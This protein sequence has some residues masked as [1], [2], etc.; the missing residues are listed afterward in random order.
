[1]T[2]GAACLALLA[3]AFGF[4][5]ASALDECWTGSTT[6]GSN[7]GLNRMRLCIDD[8][9]AVD[10]RVYFPNTPIQ[11]PPTI[12][13]ST[14]RRVEARGSTFRIVTE[15]GRCENGTAMGRYDLRCTVGV[16][17]ALSCTFPVPSGTLVNV[18]LVKV[19]P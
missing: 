11:E 2:K 13:V 17:D 18:A 15:V 6:N 19:Q 12:C 4:Q 1:M 10:L 14:G 8:D 7:P 3:V 9:D 5:R 16:A